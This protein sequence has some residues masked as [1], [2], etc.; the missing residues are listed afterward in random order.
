[1]VQGKRRDQC[2]A[3][4]W[5]GLRHWI[6]QKLW[7]YKLQRICHISLSLFQE[8]GKRNCGAVKVKSLLLAEPRSLHCNL[9]FSVL[10]GDPETPGVSEITSNY[11]TGRTHQLDRFDPAYPSEREGGSMDCVQLSLCVIL[12]SFHVLHPWPRR[13]GAWP[14]SKPSIPSF[15]WECSSIGFVSLALLSLSLFKFSFGYTCSMHKFQ[16][17]GLNPCHSSNPSHCNDNTRSL[18]HWATRELQ[19]LPFLKLVNSGEIPAHN[20]TATAWF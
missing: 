2:S 15:V 5:V 18:A 11:F 12:I 8:F 1:M 9:I 20:F 10:L 4:A 14:Q 16:G 19:A 17:Q 13:N 6:K 7:F 3:L